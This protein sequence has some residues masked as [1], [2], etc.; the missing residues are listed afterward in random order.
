MWVHT[1][2][3]ELVN[4]DHSHHI[5]I[6]EHGAPKFHI[7]V[8]AVIGSERYILAYMPKIGAEGRHMANEYVL[9]LIEQLQQHRK[10]LD[11]PLYAR[12][13]ETQARH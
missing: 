8:V 6:V 2:P 10:L 1:E 11:L 9:L 12:H 4:L 13:P 7:E 5:L 3:G